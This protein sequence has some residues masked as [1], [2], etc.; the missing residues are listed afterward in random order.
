MRTLIWC[1][2]SSLS[3]STMAERLCNI[4]KL[5][6]GPQ[7]HSQLVPTGDVLVHHLQVLDFKRLKS[8]THSV[9]T[10]GIVILSRDPAVSH[11]DFIG[12]PVRA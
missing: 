6:N 12:S 1:L 10:I 11:H 2:A 7:P 9:T 8:E 4:P 3:D 5:T